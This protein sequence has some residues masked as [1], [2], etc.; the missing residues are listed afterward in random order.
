[1]GQFTHTHNTH[2]LFT[3]YTVLYKNRVKVNINNPDY[4]VYE[5]FRNN[6]LCNF[7]ITSVAD[8]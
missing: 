4:K 2:P 5:T 7:G 1:M 6:I 3:R 8:T